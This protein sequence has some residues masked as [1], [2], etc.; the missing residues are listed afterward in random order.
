MARHVHHD[1]GRCE[2]VNGRLGVPQCQNA[3]FD[4]REESTI[5]PANDSET[6]H[7]D[8]EPGHD[9]EI[10]NAILENRSHQPGH[11]GL[12]VASLEFQ[13]EDDDAYE[14][15]EVYLGVRIPNICE[16]F[17]DKYQQARPVT[18]KPTRRSQER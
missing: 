10:E 13:D 8:V 9:E 2:T 7:R 3:S 18:C 14:S 6:D 1:R 15:N 12:A 5:Y 11:P 4:E 17:G 16:T